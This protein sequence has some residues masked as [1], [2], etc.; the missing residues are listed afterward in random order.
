MKNTSVMRRLVLSLALCFAASILPASAGSPCILSDGPDTYGVLA[1]D[2]PEG[3]A[4]VDLN[5]RGRQVVEVGPGG[6]DY[7]LTG[8]FVIDTATARTVAASYTLAD[9]ESMTVRVEIGGQVL[10]DQTLPQRDSVVGTANGHTFLP[11][12]VP[13]GSYHIVGISMG[14]GD[15]VGIEGVNDRD[16]TVTTAMAPYL[17]CDKLA[18]VGELQHF[19]ERDFRG[20][21]LSVP[22]AGIRSNVRLA[23]EN[24][25]RF[26]VGGL[27][28]RAYAGSGNDSTLDIVTPTGS[29]RVL[30]DIAPISSTAGSYSFL[31]SQRGVHSRLSLNW[32][33]YDA[34]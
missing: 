3:G 29:G 8:A 16:R 17:S 4:W 5:Y 33:T 1:W 30:R 23:L 34:P 22:G 7:M 32:L 15:G 11:G 6:D 31:A 2:V 18:V 14:G 13:Q 10:V 19:D 21:Q 24:P 20:T 25:R 26:L 28:H 12:R 27:H 9:E